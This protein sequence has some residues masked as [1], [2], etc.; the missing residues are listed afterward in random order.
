MQNLCAPE[1]LARRA[2]ALIASLMAALALVVWFGVKIGLRPLNDLQDAIQH[3]SPDD[4][5]DIRRPVRSLLLALEFVLIVVVFV[6]VVF[7]TSTE[8]EY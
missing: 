6:V 7:S 8:P 2:A 1:A 5:R 4:L 3:R